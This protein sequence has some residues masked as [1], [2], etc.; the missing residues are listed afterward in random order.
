M[1]QPHSPL[2]THES[3]WLQRHA[4]TQKYPPLTGVHKTQVAVLGA[5]ITGLSTALELL[6]RGYAVTVVEALVI[7]SGTTGGSTGHADAH[8]EMGPVALIEMLGE[9]KARQ[10]VR[11][12]QEA[13]DKIESRS[14]PESDFRRISA[15]EYSENESDEESLRSECEAAA[16]IGL[17]ARWVGRIDGLP[18]KAIGYEIEN[19]GRFDSLAYIRGLADRVTAAGGKIFEKSIASGPMEPHPT[20]LKVG[21]GQI[22]F[23][24]LV[25]A[26]H[27][28][29]TD[30]LRIYTQTP[31]YQSYVLA[32]RVENPCPDALYWDNANPYHY[33][34]W[35]RS[36]DS[37]LLIIGGC[38]HRTGMGDA[39]NAM[40][41]LEQ[42]T[43]QHF[44]VNEIVSQW[45]AE[46]FEP[47]DGMP[48]FGKVPG[49]ENVW[50]AT[51][52]SGVGLT[53][54]TAAGH[55]LAR[56]IA[57]EQ[58]PL[59]EDM[60]PSRF[61][62][63]GALTWI[64]DQMQSAANLAERVMPA[65]RFDPS[66]LKVGEGKVGMVDGKFTAA[67]RD[68]SGCVHSHNPVCVH[69]GGV[70][71]WNEAEQTWDCPFHGGRYAADGSRIYGP[72]E[73]DLVKPGEKAKQS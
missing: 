46:L 11:Y 16:K 10:Y 22:E 63:R 60:S 55:I 71:H 29:Y 42:F 18:Y 69:M 20:S 12:R 38:D 31:P 1:V 32:A 33:I 35:A 4:A 36:D 15:F 37:N 68:S 3:Y 72:P 41:K 2:T 70:V 57:G 56:Q 53:R 30:A 27:C 28:N 47:P 51:G 24:Q 73:S 50:I 58:T 65:E 5:G 39:A 21:D 44:A 40:L 34:R 23:E 17:R 67:C 25:C 8:P 62:G 6:E 59:Q 49:K 54:G 52:L 48:I 61:G 13:I 7:G 9:E 45:S 43:R 64:S 14:T 26:V 66:E 19:F